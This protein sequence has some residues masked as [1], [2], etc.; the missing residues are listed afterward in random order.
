MNN[1]KLVYSTDMGRIQSAIEKT[2]QNAEINDGT[3]RVSRQ[4]Q[5]R[6]GK[7]VILLTGFIL[8]PNALKQLA[9]LLKQAC[10]SGGTVKGNSIEIQGDQILRVIDLLNAQG[11]KT[12]RVG[13]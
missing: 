4:T 3:I 10:S 1:S 7:G 11:F 5:G 8:E 12:L 6:K 13:G 9:K 2:P